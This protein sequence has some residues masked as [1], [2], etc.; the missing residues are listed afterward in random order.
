MRKTILFLML[1]AF[2]LPTFGQ[3]DD[4]ANGTLTEPQETAEVTVD[5]LTVLTTDTLPFPLNIRQRIDTLLTARMLQ[6]SQ[7]GLMVYDLTADS[8]I[9]A[10]NER[11]TMRPASTEKLVT[12]ITAI[13]RLGGSYQFRTSLY[14]SGSIGDGVICSWWGAWIPPSDTMT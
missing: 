14:C 1:A 11:Q 5:S 6:R 4:A 12:A 3:N 8:L 9:Y 13:D 2:V 10:Y 7:V